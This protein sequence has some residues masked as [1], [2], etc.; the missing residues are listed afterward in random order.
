MKVLQIGMG[1]NPGGVESFVMNYYR[2]LAPLGIQFDFISMYGKIAFEEE[3]LR[4]GGSVFYVPNVKKDYRGYLKQMRKIFKNR[5]YDAVHVNMLSAAN[6]VP[7]RLAKEA[8]VSQ[9]IAHSH[10]ASAPG[11]VRKLMDKVNRPKIPRYATCLAACGEKAGR[12]LFGDKIFNSGRV[13]LLQNAIDVNRFLFNSEN[14]DKIREKYGWGDQFVIGHVGR[15]EYQKNHEAVL[16]LFAQAKQMQPDAI[17]CLVG[18]GILR[19]E[20]EQKAKELGIYESV[21]FAGVQMHVEEYLSAMDV[22]ILPS[23][24][25][26]LPFTLVEAQANGLPCVISDVITD[27]IVVNKTQVRQMS[28]SD[29]GKNWAEAILKARALRRTDTQISKKEITDAHFDIH[30]EAKRLQKLY[31]EKK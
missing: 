17:L 13:F 7:L 28:L 29:S 14:R 9:I 20:M 15:F 16:D 11:L 25:E 26:G 31:Q 6:I 8:G 2:E 23:H 1:N 3:I 24:F 30:T 5:N 10:N 21:C 27:E 12:W 18:D 19:E 22:F 4:L